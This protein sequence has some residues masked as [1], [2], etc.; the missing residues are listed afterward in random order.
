[1]CSASLTA[2][3]AGAPSVRT[4]VTTPA[5]A[6]GRLTAGCRSTRQ[7]SKPT[8]QRPPQRPSKAP[9]HVGNSHAWRC[10]QPTSVRAVRGDARAPRPKHDPRESRARIPDLNPLAPAPPHLARTPFQYAELARGG[11]RQ[12]APAF[13]SCFAG[14]AWLAAGARR[15]PTGFQVFAE[16]GRAT[17][18]VSPYVARGYATPC[19]QFENVQKLRI[20]A[21]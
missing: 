17:C 10:G 1:M 20:F 11:R 21:P 12:R 14:A 9:R 4:H 7:A 13:T 8:A 19:C 2:D 16:D 3:H 18:S 15:R 5:P 6:Y